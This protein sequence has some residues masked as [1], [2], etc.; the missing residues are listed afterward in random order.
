M[1]TN[2]VLDDDLVRSAL[3]LSGFKT[4]KRAIEEGLKLLIQVNRQRKIKDF[5]GK[6]KWKGNLNRMR[7]DK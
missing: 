5:R 3:S 6:L 1:R 4:K 7:T 2:V